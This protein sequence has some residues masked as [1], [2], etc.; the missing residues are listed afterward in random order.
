V[1]SLMGFFCRFGSRSIVQIRIISLSSFPDQKKYFFFLF[2]VNVA[3]VVLVAAKSERMS[4]RGCV[5]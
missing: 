5:Y 1:F 2:S 4:E 3:N